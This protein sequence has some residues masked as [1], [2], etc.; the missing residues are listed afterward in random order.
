MLLDV[1][2]NKP[3]IV[4]LFWLTVL[5][6]WKSWFLSWLYFVQ[7]NKICSTVSKWLQCW[8]F[9]VGCFPIIFNEELSP[10]CPI[11]NRVI[12]LSSLLLLLSVLPIFTSG[13][14]LYKCLPLSWSTQ[15]S[16]HLDLAYALMNTLASDLLYGTCNIL[17]CFSVCFASLSTSS[18]P[19]TPTCAGT[20][21]NLI[22]KSF[23]F[24]LYKTIQILWIISFLIDFPDL[25]LSKAE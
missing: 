25:M 1:F 6:D 16:C 11:L 22:F 9:P 18:F 14:I 4:K 7:W 5:R 10:V 20:Q 17:L 8:H 24:N 15:Y 2:P 12:I 19:F 3:C 13:C 23:A 21:R